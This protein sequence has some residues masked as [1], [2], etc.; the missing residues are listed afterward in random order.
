MADKKA[1]KAYSRDHQTDTGQRIAKFI[2]GDVLAGIP[3]G[4]NVLAPLLDPVR[5]HVTALRPGRKAAG[6]APLPMP[7]DR[8]RGSDAKPSRRR[9]AT[10]A[11][12][13]RRQDP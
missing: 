10:H 13:N 4:Q 5:P 2:Q 12:V 3:D 1:V 9:T 6:I 8:R 7:P 11:R